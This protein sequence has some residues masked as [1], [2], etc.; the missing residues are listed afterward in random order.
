MANETTVVFRGG[1][2]KKEKDNMACK[3]TPSPNCKKLYVLEPSEEDGGMN[4][5][6]K[7]GKEE[8]R[9]R[10]SIVINSER[11]GEGKERGKPKKKICETDDMTCTNRLIKR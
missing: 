4:S 10:K 1:L 5:T 7:C 11:G 3:K 8:H 6:Q 2:M 9:G